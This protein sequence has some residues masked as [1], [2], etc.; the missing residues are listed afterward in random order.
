MYL[1]SK[2]LIL[3]SFLQFLSAQMTKEKFAFGEPAYACDKFFLQAT[4]CNLDGAQIL[5]LARLGS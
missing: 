4:A 3:Y 2:N 1:V 5:H